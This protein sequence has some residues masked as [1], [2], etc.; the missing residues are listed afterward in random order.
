MRLLHAS[1]QQAA[2]AKA[3]A[4]TQTFAER[5]EA[6]VQEMENCIEGN[7]RWRVINMLD[8]LVEFYEFVHAKD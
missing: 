1:K 7:Y 5:M 4:E 3:V 6:H 2:V 8:A